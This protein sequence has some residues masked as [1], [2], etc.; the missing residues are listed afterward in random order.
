MLYL[1]ST[2]GFS[3]ARVAELQQHSRAAPATA[4]A[5]RQALGGVRAA[6]AFD[7]HAALALLDALLRGECD[8]PSQDAPAD[9]EEAQQRPALLI[10]DSAS[11]LLSPLL[12]TAHPQGE[13]CLGC[14]SSR[15]ALSRACCAGRALMLTLTG[16]LRALADEHAVAV[17]VR[18]WPLPPCRPRFL[19][20]HLPVPADE[21]HRERPRRRNRVAQASAR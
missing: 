21:P 5:A 6:R 10:V 19:T 1:D 20:Q 12:T 13:S 8:A 9:G 17:L 3:A 11:A 18:S 15:T 4:E 2:G 7:V 14:V 16:A